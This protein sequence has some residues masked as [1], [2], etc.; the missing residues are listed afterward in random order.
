MRSSRSHL[1]LRLRSVPLARAS[2]FL[3][4]RVLYSI[5]VFFRHKR[6][7][8][9]YRLPSEVVKS[10][11]RRAFD[12]FYSQDD[13]VETDYLRDSRLAFIDLI[14]DYCAPE[15]ADHPNTPGDFRLIDVGCG[16]GHFL[17]ALQKRF[18]DAAGALFGMD[19]SRVAISRA[20]AHISGA[21]FV[22]ADIYAIPYPNSYFDVVT[23]IETMEHLKKPQLALSELVRICKP[24]GRLVITV[25]D[26]TDDWGGHVNFWTT[27]SLRSFL[28]PTGIVEITEL[29]EYGALLARVTLIPAVHSGAD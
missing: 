5:S 26:G 7:R 10:N 2:W 6:D 23:S 29:P 11:T 18:G 19:F 20:R 17:L 21:E 25:P 16:T 14:A 27:D 8:W 3:Y 28:A 1:V 22:E 24:N 13:F 15:F 4:R 9:I 12:Y